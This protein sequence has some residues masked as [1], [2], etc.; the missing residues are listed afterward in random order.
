MFGNQF[1]ISNLSLLRWD[2]KKKDI[3]IGKR[4]NLTLIYIIF[5]IIKCC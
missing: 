4:R 1:A 2:I 3:Y 5:I